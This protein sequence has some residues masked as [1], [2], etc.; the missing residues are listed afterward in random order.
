MSEKQALKNNQQ[1]KQIS[2][3][4]SSISKDIILLKESIKDIQSEVRKINMIEDKIKK[5]ES[6]Q[7]SNDG[8]FL[9]S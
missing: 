6:I 9:W 1:L 3:D 8:W 2:A 7:K 5:G 4:L